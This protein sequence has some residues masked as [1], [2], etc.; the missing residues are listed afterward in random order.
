MYM[1]NSA[2]RY[3]RHTYAASTISVRYVMSGRCHPRPTH[4]LMLIVVCRCAQTWVS[5]SS[6]EVSNSYSTRSTALVTRTGSEHAT[7]R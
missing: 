5:G 7:S 6:R 1:Y 4:K 2:R 3:R